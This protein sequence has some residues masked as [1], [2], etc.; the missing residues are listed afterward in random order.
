[1]RQGKP[2]KTDPAVLAKYRA[3]A[4]EALLA[5]LKSDI[6]QVRGSAALALG[7]IG[8]P[9]ALAPLSALAAKD[10][11]EAV[12]LLSIIGIGLLDLPEGEKFLTALPCADSVHREAVLCAL[13]LMDNASPELVTSFQK[14]VN[15]ADPAQAAIAAW[16]LSRKLDPANVKFLQAVLDRTL[17][18]WLASEA[19][20]ST[21]RQG[22]AESA[23]PLAEVLLG[24]PQGRTFPAWKELDLRRAEVTMAYARAKTERTVYQQAYA[25]YAKKASDYNAKYN[26]NASAPGAAPVNTNVTHLQA[27][28][29]DIYMAR[30]Q[31]SA[32]IAL[33]SID[34]PV[35]RK[36]LLKCMEAHDDGYSQLYKEFAVLSLAQLGEPAL[37]PILADLLAPA[38]ATGGRKSSEKLRSPLRGFAAIA[39]GLYSRP[40]KTAQGTV[41][42][43]GYDKACLILANRMTDTA[44]EMEVRAASTVALGLTGR[45]ENLRYLQAAAKTIGDKDD[46]LV[47]YLLM[48]RG[49]LEDKTILEP[50][51]K[52]LAAAND[53]SDTSGILG[54]RGAIIGLALMDSQ[55][56]IPVLQNAWNLSY[57]S[58]REVCTALALCGA[59]NTTD[60]LVKLMK[61]A[62]NPW[63]RAFA[64]RCLGELF[65]AQ[66]P[67]KL[68]RLING[69]NF[70]LKNNRLMRYQALANEFLYLHLLPAFGNEWR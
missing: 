65:N 4:V 8:D 38:N 25:D 13:G 51:K 24:S 59:Y 41:D 34:T 26:P 49:M 50:A 60:G 16:A 48:A 67:Q 22:Q 70:M 14:T 12:T 68:A 66:R 31:G 7:Q 21:G 46:L 40:V 18:V 1:M 33:G 23:E 6:V 56:A 2:Q 37:L 27:G 61:D 63:E 3:T 10:P 11:T 62:N 17:N 52:Y 28:I 35:S 53:K 29:E 54:R 47:G 19:L 58:N 36:A 43:E 42:R 30:M 44:E 57:H 32:A 9:Q 20:L 5:A 64:A 69:T 39:I 15:G 55:E 45:S